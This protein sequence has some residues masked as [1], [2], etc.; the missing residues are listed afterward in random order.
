MNHLTEEQL[1]LHYYGEPAES[2]VED[3]LEACESCRVQYRGLQRVLNT[4]DSAPV[5]D[6]PPE[7]GTVVWRKIESRVNGRRRV[8]WPGARGWLLAGAMAALILAAFLAG[9]FSQ[10]PAAPSMANT[11]PVRERILLVAVGDHLE[12]SQT[13]LVELENSSSPDITYERQ[14]AA[15]LV[16]SN[17]LFRQTAASTGD[18]A[19][20]SLLEDL[21]RI[22]LEISNSPSEM[23]GRQLRDLQKEIENRGILFKVKVFASQVQEREKK[24]QI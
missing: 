2:P 13:I 1:V 17:R 5:P 14:A 23:S 8:A 21:E 3:H 16:E 7:Y 10:R 22:L 6:R 20:A 12:R 19:T 24:D 18:T 9:R 11:G 15:D 4:L